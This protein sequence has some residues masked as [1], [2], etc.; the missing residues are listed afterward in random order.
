MLKY[1]RK[2]RLT[3]EVAWPLIVS[4][5]LMFAA[6]MSV[7]G[8]RATRINPKLKSYL[9]S[10]IKEGRARGV[11]VKFDGL[12]MIFGRTATTKKPKIVGVCHYGFAAPTVVV[13]HLYWATASEYQREELIFHELGH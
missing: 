2:R 5:M 4:V 3:T 6:L 9:S 10:F 13:D 1:K 8:C 11:K 7:S 12:A